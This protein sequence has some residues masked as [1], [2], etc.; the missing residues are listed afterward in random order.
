[1]AAPANLTVQRSGA[2]R[3]ARRQIERHRRLAPVAD[4][5]VGQAYEKHSSMFVLRFG[6]DG[7][8]HV[9][10]LRHHLWILR[11]ADARTRRESG[12]A[13][14]DFLRKG[15]YLLRDVAAG[16]VMWMGIEW[17]AVIATRIVKRHLTRL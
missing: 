11:G 15:G 16:D 8:L 7:L 6:C 14:T 13:P 1:M 12:L 9:V 17:S 5:F 10:G 4:L 2:S 3:F